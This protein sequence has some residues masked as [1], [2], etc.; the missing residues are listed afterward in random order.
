MTL[1]NLTDILH[2]KQ[3]SLEVEGQAE[4]ADILTPQQLAKVAQVEILLE[5]VGG[6]SIDDELDAM[7]AA[8]TEIRDR[9]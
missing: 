6:F 9:P 5:Q 1:L 3:M 2:I 7:I 8:L 4:V